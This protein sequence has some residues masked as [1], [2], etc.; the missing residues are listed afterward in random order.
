VQVHSYVHPV[1]F[2]GVGANAAASALSAVQQQPHTDV[3]R[4]YMSEVGWGSSDQ[5][6]ATAAG[7][8]LWC[9][10]ATHLLHSDCPDQCAKSSLRSRHHPDW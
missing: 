1:I 2:C 8:A 10:A 6:P 5:E 7:T 3:L 9:C 4:A